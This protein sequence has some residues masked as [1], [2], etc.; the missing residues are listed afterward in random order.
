MQRTTQQQHTTSYNSHYDDAMATAV[1]ST[2][3]PAA[4][5]AVRTTLKRAR[6][7]SA[8]ACV[9]FQHLLMSLSL[10][11]CC[12]E[13]PC[14]LLSALSLNATRLSD[15]GTLSLHRALCESIQKAKA[16]KNE[17][18]TLPMGYCMTRPW[19]ASFKAHSMTVAPTFLLKSAFWYGY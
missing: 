11:T 8:C 16:Q 14:C 3:M 4:V 15:G 10:P 2:T 17:R 9:V 6:M 7:F 1:T 18:C 12:P 13:V 5:V 19:H